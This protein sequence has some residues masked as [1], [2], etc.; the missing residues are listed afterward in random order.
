MN[1]PVAP[2]WLRTMRP[3]ANAVNRDNPTAFLT[4]QE[5]LRSSLRYG[6]NP[7]YG[8]GANCMVRVHGQELWKDYREQSSSDPEKAQAHEAP[9][10]PLASA[11]SPLA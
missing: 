11:D 7:G 6:T 10:I 9:P 3:M 8:D 4:A 5:P 2:R 1:G